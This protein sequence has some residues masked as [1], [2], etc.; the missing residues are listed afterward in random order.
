MSSSSLGESTEVQ[1]IMMELINQLDGFDPRGNVKVIMATNRPETLDP[2][3]L[4]PGRLDRRIE[5]GPPDFEG[6]MDIFKIH[7]RR[8]PLE[9]DVRFELMARKSV[10]LG[11]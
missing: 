9:Q 1:R 2:A 7:T 5:F 4:R 6:L 8:M 11:E 3:L 10:N